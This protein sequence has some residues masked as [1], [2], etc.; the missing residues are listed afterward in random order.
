M[1]KLVRRQSSVNV[2]NLGSHKRAEDEMK[3]KIL[4][5]ANSIVNE[6]ITRKKLRYLERVKNIMKSQEYH[7]KCLQIEQGIKKVH[8]QLSDKNVIEELRLM[9]IAENTKVE[10]DKMHKKA[11]STV[12]L[13][14]IMN[15]IIDDSTH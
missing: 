11:K 13:S 6:Y 1:K 7:Q 15:E 14:T 10:Q 12:E 9:M 3:K 4:E 8:S 5:M 2:M